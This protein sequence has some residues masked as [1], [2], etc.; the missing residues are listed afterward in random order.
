MN[1]STLIYI[2][3]IKIK[4]ILR[5]NLISSFRNKY[6]IIYIIIIIRY[7]KLMSSDPKV[8]IILEREPGCT[9][10]DLYI[11]GDGNEFEKF[12]GYC[13]LDMNSEFGSPR[14]ARET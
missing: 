13:D 10:E 11:D 7:S 12:Q 2:N 4:C 8:A 1:H 3:Y 6:V 5:G 14:S 9:I